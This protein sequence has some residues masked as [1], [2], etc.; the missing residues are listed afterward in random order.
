MMILIKNKILYFFQLLVISANYIFNKDFNERKIIKQYVQ[1]NGIVFDVGS[2]IGSFFKFVSKSLKGKNI[3]IHSFEPGV[4]SCEFQKN[5]KIPRNY[6][7]FINNLAVLD[8]ESREVKF[9]E[10][11]ISSHSSTLSKPQMSAISGELDSYYVKTVSIDKYCQDNNISFIDLLKVDAEGA[12]FEVL[13]SCENMLINKNIKLIK[14]EV[15]VNKETPSL[16]FQY[17]LKFDYKLLGITNLSY[18]D[19]ELKFFDAYFAVSK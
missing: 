5:L 1:N 9:Y 17:L 7:L 14:T 8:G 4:K 13:K 10:R 6:K 2:N 15:W 19:N 12:D 16:I 18:L 3:H 11:S